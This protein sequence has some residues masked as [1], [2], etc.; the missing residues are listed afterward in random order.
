MNT[1]NF[2]IARF[3]NFKGNPPHLGKKDKISNLKIDVIINNIAKTRRNDDFNFLDSKGD[4]KRGNKRGRRFYN[5]KD[6]NKSKKIR[7]A[8]L[9]KY[10][11][12]REKLKS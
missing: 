2:F 9:N 10:H 12:E 7:V 1:V 5:R 3:N 8:K 4:L 11:G 6:N